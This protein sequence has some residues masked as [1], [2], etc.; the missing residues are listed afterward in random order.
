MP[1]GIEIIRDAGGILLDSNIET[2]SV[3]S[4]GRYPTN[5]VPAGGLSQMVATG[6]VDTAGAYNWWLFQVGAAGTTRFGL[7]VF[8]ADGRLTFCASRQTMRLVDWFALG[9]IG[10]ANIVRSY[11]AGRVYAAYCSV[12]RFTDV[13]LQGAGMAQQYRIDSRRSFAR[14]S[15]RTVTAGWDSIEISDWRPVPPGGQESFPAP[16]YSPQVFIIDV[17]GY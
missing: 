7:Q 13:Q 17:T 16:T 10:S 8:D 15:G 3:Y 6:P 2:V 5:A 4:K 14:M 11:P 9:P 12:T 1:A